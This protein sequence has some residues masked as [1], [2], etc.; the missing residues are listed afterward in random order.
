MYGR[1]GYDFDGCRL[2]VEIAKGRGNVEERRPRREFRPP[3]TGHRV[4]VEGLPSSASWQD[5]KDFIRQVVRPA[6]TNVEKGRDGALGIVEFET[7]SDMDRAIQKLDDT[8]FKNPF[9]SSRVRFVVDR[10]GGGGRG[11]GS[12]GRGGRSRS[13]SRSRSPY[14]PR[15]RDRSPYNNNRDD[16]GDRDDYRE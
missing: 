12:E 3:N 9:G 2:R 14:D 10:D 1:D 8:E 5:L 16:R 11:G 13:R 15:R 4:L 6:Y 7:A